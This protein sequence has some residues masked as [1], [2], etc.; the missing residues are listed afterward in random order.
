M[1]YKTLRLQSSTL[2]SL[3]RYR[4][5][6]QVTVNRNRDAY[7]QFKG[8]GRV[9]LDDALMMLI[10]QQHTHSKRA[11]SRRVQGERDK[12]AFCDSERQHMPNPNRTDGDGHSF[13]PAETS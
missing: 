8:N 4:D 10:H 1:I 6:L 2:E 5:N 7:P 3:S 11:R 12:D 9:T 13:D